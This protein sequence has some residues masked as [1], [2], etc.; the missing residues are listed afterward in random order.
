VYLEE[1]DANVERG[2]VAH[3]P[4]GV[5]RVH[6][7]VNEEVHEAEEIATAVVVVHVLAGVEAEGVRDDVVVVVEEVE[8]ALPEDDED[9]VHELE[10]LGHVEDKHPDGAITERVAVTGGADELPGGQ[11]A[12]GI[13]PVDDEG[14]DDREEA[15]CGEGGHEEIPQDERPAEVVRLAILHPRLET[16]DSG[17]VGHA[18]QHEEPPMPPDEGR[19]V[20]LP[21]LPADPQIGSQNRLI[22]G[23]RRR[24]GSHF[25]RLD[26][27]RQQDR[28]GAIIRLL[29]ESNG[30]R[31]R[32][33]NSVVRKEATNT[34]S[35]REGLLAGRNAA[36]RSSI[37]SVFSLRVT[38]LQQK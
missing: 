11:A 4:Q 18:S 14:V 24:S 30:K 23:Q 36:R 29:L 9:R 27:Q 25:N 28:K 37:S 7:A 15:H 1:G 3:G 33:A 5:V 8:G 34:K 38:P 17:Q 2:V 22:D 26:A 19:R 32:G 31:R 21:G 13:N 16:E 6:D 10:N 20:G 12:A 35:G